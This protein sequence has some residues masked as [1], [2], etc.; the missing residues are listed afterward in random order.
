MRLFCFILAMAGTDFLQMVSKKDKGFQNWAFC[1]NT[2]NFQS[3]L[4]APSLSPLS[5]AL[6]KVARSRKSAN[7]D[8]LS[9]NVITKPGFTHQQIANAFGNGQ[10]INEF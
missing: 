6:N 4:A 7:S 9:V 10:E 3:Q 1:T 5:P 8:L 2:F